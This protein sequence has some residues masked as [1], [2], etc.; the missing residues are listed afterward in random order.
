MDFELKNDK[1]L[2]IC[3]FL[4]Y[5]IKPV[6]YFLGQKWFIEMCDIVSD[7]LQNVV[8]GVNGHSHKTIFIHQSI[9]RYPRYFFIFI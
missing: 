2:M 4:A 8:S 6:Y 5:N 3:G 7:F 9:N 1:R